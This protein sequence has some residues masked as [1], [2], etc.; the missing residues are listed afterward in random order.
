MALTQVTG[1]EIRGIVSVVPSETA[2][3][4]D[5]THLFSVDEL[6]RVIDSTGI[7]H[8]RVAGEGQTVLTM[9]TVA[10]KALLDDLAWETSPGLLVCITQT[11]DYVLPGNAVQLQHRLGLAKDTVA[12]DVNL[13]CS[14]FVYGLWQAATLL[15]ALPCGRALLVVGDTTTHM[16]SGEQSRP[17]SPLFGDAVSVIALEK[18]ADAMPMHFSLGSDGA[19]APYLIQ[20]N[21]AA[22]N[23]QKAPALTMDGTQVFVFTLREV[24]ASITAVLDSAAI[25]VSEVDTVVMHQANEMML[26]RLADKLGVDN[27]QLLIAMQHRGNTSSASIPL[28]ITDALSD[29]L[30]STRQTLLLSGFG[31]GWSWGSAVIALGPLDVCKTLEMPLPELANK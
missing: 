25:K 29:K 31:V 2:D 12:F 28:A 15:A 14:G 19:G 21:G 5:L 1:V 10:A 27:S 8:R 16:C 17:V 13:G 24:P 22:L 7:V 20:P 4:H 26:K 30:A 23:P 6:K 11:P 18:S 3:N 9:A